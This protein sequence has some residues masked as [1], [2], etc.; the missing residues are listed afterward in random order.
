MILLSNTTS[1]L[2]IVTGSSVSSINV[3]AS[4]IDL[5]GT[6]LTP[7]STNTLISSAAT[8][9]VIGSPAASTQRSVKNL[10]VYN[11]SASSCEVTI[12]HYDGTTTVDIFNYTML[13]GES[14]YWSEGRGFYVLDANGNLKVT[15]GSSNAFTFNAYT[16]SASII[17]GANIGFVSNAST[18]TISA[19][20]QTGSLSY[21]Q[22]LNG[23]SSTVS[24]SAGAGIGIGNGASTITISAS[25]QTSSVSLTALG[26]TT[27]SSSGTFSNLLNLS[28][29][30]IVS[31]GVGAGSITISA[32][33]PSV[34]SYVSITTAAGGSTTGTTA[35]ITGPFVLV[36]GNE[37]TLSQ[38]TGI[39]TNSTLS[40]G[41]NAIVISGPS[42]SVAGGL[43]VT[44]G[45]V[46]S[47]SITNHVSSLNGSSGTL[48]ISAGAGIGI[49]NAA[50]T[51]TISASVQTSLLSDYAIGNTTS[52]SSGTW[53]NALSYSGAGIVSIGAGNGTITISATTPSVTNFSTISLSASGNTTSSSSGT[54]NNVLAIS[55]L[56]II[57]VG[58][59]NGSFTIS[60]TTPSVTN[61]STITGSMAGNTLGA[62][63]TTVTIGNGF[64]LSGAGIVSVG[65]SGN[66]ITISASTAA[67]ANV[68][69]YV[70]ITTAAGGSTTGTTASITGPFVLVAGNEITL[71]QNTGTGTNSTLSSG[72]NAIVIS[73]PSFS[74]AG[75]L[76]VTT[77]S[78]ISLSITNHVSSL[79]GSSGTL[80][81]SAGANI[82]IGNAGNTITIS[83]SSYS[84]LVS[85]TTV[86]G[87]ASSGTVNTASSSAF[88]FVAGT[89]ITLSQ[90]STSPA[91][92]IIG[93]ATNTVGTVLTSITS[94]AGGATSGTANTASSTAFALVAG[95][96]ITLSQLS[97]SPN[98]TVVGLPE[99]TQSISG[100]GTSV[101]GTAISF[102]LVGGNNISLA[103]ASGAGSLTLT[104]NASSNALNNVSLLNGSS[105]ALSVSAGAGI[106]I[107][108]AG[109]TITISASVQTSSLSLTAL[110]NT[111]L[112]SSGTAS[113]LLNISGAGNV[114]VGISNN[115]IYISG[116]TAAAAAAV[117]M[118]A[119]GN[120]TSS[121][122]GTFSTGLVFSGAG[123]ASVGVG[124]GSVTISVPSPAAATNFSLNGTSSSVSLVN[125][126]GIQLL[127]NAS[128]ITIQAAFVAG[129]NITLSTGV[130]SPVVTVINGAMS[131]L[132]LTQQ[133]PL[134]EVAGTIVSGAYTS[135]TQTLLN[136]SLFLQR[137]VIAAPIAL[138]EVDMAM[139]ISGNGGAATLS[140]SFVLYSFGNSTSLASVVSASSAFA[141][142]TGT[143]TVAGSTSLTQFYGGWS[144][145]AIQPLTFASSLVPAGEYVVGN[146][147]AFNETGTN[148]AE[149]YLFGGNGLSSAGVAVTISTQAIPQFSTVS[150]SV[151]TNTANSAITAFTAAPTA[152]SALSSGG[153]AAISAF[154]SSASSAL[155]AFTAA[156][157]G[158][159]AM[160][161]IGLA[162]ASGLTGLS[163]LSTG[164]AADTNW[165]V[166][167][168]SS[169]ASSASADLT[170]AT[171]VQASYVASLATLAGSIHTNSSSGGVI[172]NLG[173][174][175]VSLLSTGGLSAGSFIGT[176]GSVAAI[177]N[178]GTAAVTIL[179]GT[180]NVA[181]TLQTATS[182][183]VSAVTA[184]SLQ[185]AGE[186]FSPIAFGISALPNF[187]YIGTGS[188]TSSAPGQF[189]H[190]IAGIMS[191]GAAPASIALTSTAVTYTGSYAFQQPW[192]ALVGA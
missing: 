55:G 82:G 65:A 99:G 79:N 100:G 148:V 19:S 138:S 130:A 188:T 76:A 132:S 90:N 103:S 98:I 57:S 137:I 22:S 178:V 120:T 89:G 181:A 184:A 66:T 25:V 8:T 21:V 92:T 91:I 23:S 10:C 18:I 45:S 34:V 37:I 191:T 48:S 30:G 142:T 31:V 152:A 123:I 113:N 105:G 106:G 127:S 74:V 43:A 95:S 143:S 27:S 182:A 11:S 176:S 101:T 189:S 50:N 168:A 163:S 2:Q 78:V 151:L 71:S 97:T 3:Q 157:T 52:S 84:T 158:F 80:S 108:N 140:S 17:P 104:I 5:I 49:G 145:P 16:G 20:N 146:L 124:A 166:T 149:L 170:V 29:A 183:A 38:N 41:S 1:L 93:V 175:G 75:G 109:S 177:S 128:T 180:G 7:L 39:G 69:S 118:S 85:I 9:T 154:T 53:S 121:S 139:S 155:T 131:R 86:A 110:G 112:S 172:S 173:T 26:N 70:S 185:T 171:L 24:I 64:S 153:L 186:Q 114:S 133:I 83:A 126:T 88:P 141:Y 40:S 59:G 179:T 167:H 58:A 135:S 119:S 42:F 6:L 14:I 63:S 122:T 136:S 144:A 174:A 129:N 102:A 60:A 28:G 13:T 162:A 72:S 47:L 12:Q 54:M 15:T 77:G 187:V 169:T 156:P 62:A 117:S 51:I 160:S 81:I 134:Q 159:S 68:V 192:F 164:Q 150:A 46:I 61:F 94:A 125:G 4:Y 36:A 161:S 165:F 111:T 190:F 35:S 33:T 116:G 147:L 44:T 115:T 67:S 87:G 32:T 96:N 107:G 73:G 56:G